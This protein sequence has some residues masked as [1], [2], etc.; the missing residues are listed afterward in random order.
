MAQSSLLFL[1]FHLDPEAEQLWRGEQRIPLRPKARAVLHYL[2]VQR[3]R[4]VPKAALLKAA[5][6]DTVVTEAVLKVCIQ[7]IRKALGDDADKPRYIETVLRKGYRFIAPVTAFAAPVSSAKFH[8]Q[9]SSP[10][11][12]PNPQ[13]PA[14]TLV[15]RDAEL[16]RLHDC[17]E[18]AR[19]GHRQIVFVTGEPGSSKTALVEAF[20]HSL[21]SSVQCLASEDTRRQ[22]SDD[23]TLDPRPQTL[24]A[25]VWIARGQCI[26]HYGASE[27]YLPILEGLERLCQEP[28]HE[29]LVPLL[30]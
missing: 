7:E 3:E 10:H 27:A 19:Q 4:V 16:A 1:P 18:K 17:L 5:W 30:R 26:E 6:P 8:V 21:A 23:R 29:R 13:H 20:L 28:G 14:P 11:P 25:C 15:G 12:I 24:D 9:S 2:I 22:P